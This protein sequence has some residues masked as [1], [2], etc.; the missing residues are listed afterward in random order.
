MIS[1]KFTPNQNRLLEAAKFS[2]LYDIITHIPEKLVHFLPLERAFSYIQ[3]DEIDTK[4]QFRGAATLTQI[5]KRFS[6]R[7]YLVLHW[8]TTSG[9]RFSTFLF[10][11]ARFTL[12]ALA[13]NEVYLVTI[14]KSKKEFFNLVAYKKYTNNAAALPDL[15]PVYGSR[16][17]L[18]SNVFS[19]LIRRL[20]PV[21]FYL[22]LTGLVPTGHAELPQ[23][24]NL[25]PIH[26]PS[27][28]HDFE[29]ARAQWFTFQSYLSLTV[30]KAFSQ[31]QHEAFAVAA[32][33]D[34]TFV[35]SVIAQLP[36]TLSESQKKAI[37]QIYGSI[38]N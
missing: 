23:V 35:E 32:R 2:S 1:S 13:E 16:G 36:Y 7:M 34:D 3:I 20:T 26:F 5:E 9:L 31:Q 33:R 28:E 24:L 12:A 21:D 38:S 14:Q 8:K 27:S 37:W 25:R 10:S 11:V 29:M 18:T 22:N 30:A 19:A 4:P 15:L 6:G 17:M